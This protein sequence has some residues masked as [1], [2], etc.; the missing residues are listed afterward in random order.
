MLECD[1]ESH[2]KTTTRKIKQEN[3]A[4]LQSVSV[5]TVSRRLLQLGHCT[6]NPTSKPLLSRRH[7]NRR[8]KL[9][10]KYNTWT[11]EQLLSV[12]W[13]D[14]ATFT[15]TYNTGDRVYRHKGSDDP[16][17]P[18]YVQHTKTPTFFNGMGFIHGM[19]FML[20]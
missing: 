12:L 17:D 19:G 8:V 4:A 2:V 5:R 9:T 7:K 11:K 10:Q 20:G 14:E 18:R 6:N 3:A 15:V 13:S 1:V 16:L